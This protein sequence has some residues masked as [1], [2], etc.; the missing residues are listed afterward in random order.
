MCIVETFFSY[1]VRR[2][3]HSEEITALRPTAGAGRLFLRGTKLLMQ[4]KL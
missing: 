4:A 1:Q 2:K 3:L